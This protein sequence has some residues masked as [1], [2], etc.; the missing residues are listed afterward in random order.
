[1]GNAISDQRA[2]EALTPALLKEV[3]KYTPQNFEGTRSKLLQH[4]TG[5][6]LAETTKPIVLLALRHFFQ[7]NSQ[8]RRT[9]DYA[10]WQAFFNI[11]RHAAEEA[12][13]SSAHDR[14]RKALVC[15]AILVIYYD[16]GENIHTLR[17]LLQDLPQAKIGLYQK[18]ES[19]IEQ[20]FKTM[21]NN[22]ASAE[23]RG[24]NMPRYEVKSSTAAGMVTCVVAY[25]AAGHELRATGDCCSTKKE[26]EESAAQALWQQMQEDGLTAA[27]AA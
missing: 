5:K 9:V 13:C 18:A 3:F 21:L 27:Q 8:K 24:K 14:W 4:V 1:M 2:L 12:K 11:H 25:T 20:S 23:T 22:W 26:A 17:D 10:N 7:T 6:K 16:S 19:I 15:A